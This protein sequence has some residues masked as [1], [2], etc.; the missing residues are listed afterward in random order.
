MVSMKYCMECGTQLPQRAK[1][2]SSCG[3]SQSGDA[4]VVW[5]DEAA[6]PEL[7]EPP[8]PAPPMSPPVTPQIAALPPEPRS[9]PAFDDVRDDDL[10]AEPEPFAPPPPPSFVDPPPV[11]VASHAFREPFSSPTDEPLAATSVLPWEQ[12]GRDD[13]VP[14]PA[15]AYP[16]EDAPID[17]EPPPTAA[18]SLAAYVDEQRPPSFWGDGF[19]T[20]NEPPQFVSEPPPFASEPPMQPVKRQNWIMRHKLVAATTAVVSAVII[21]AAVNS[22]G[23]PGTATSPTPSASVAQTPG[24][25]PSVAPGSADQQVAIGQSATVGGVSATVTAANFQQSLDETRADGYLVVDVTYAN[26]SGQAKQFN[27]LD[28]K[29]RSPTGNT[30][31]SEQ[32]GTDGQLTS[33]ELTDGGT[34]AGKVTFKVGAEKGDFKVIWKPDAVDPARGVWT[35]PVV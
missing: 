11:P 19:E 27:S 4:P 18:A 5:S 29:A 23:D 26:M 30:I 22:T 17:L 34:V 20:P 15:S 28:W 24:L 1:F 35:T 33:G 13:L 25:Q 9:E 32:V 12:E 7:H 3:L 2:C 8:V 21:A 14:P 6:V 16:D 10:G 31:G